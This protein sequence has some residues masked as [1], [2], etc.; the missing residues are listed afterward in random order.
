MYEVTL[1]PRDNIGDQTYGV[2]FMQVDNVN[3]CIG[4]QLYPGWRMLESVLE[5]A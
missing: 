1:A 5:P 3:D 2:L 4:S